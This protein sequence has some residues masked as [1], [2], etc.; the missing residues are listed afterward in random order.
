MLLSKEQKRAFDEIESS[1]NPVFITG[2]A[3]TGKSHLLKYLRQNSKFKANTIVAAFM[4]IA[5]LNVDGVTLHKFALKYQKSG[6]FFPTENEFQRFSRKKL[7]VIKNT[8]Q[9][10]IDEVSLV[11]AD[12]IDAIDRVFRFARKSDQP[13]GGVKMVMF[14][15]LFQLPPFVKN[16]VF[17]EITFSHIKRGLKFLD[18]YEIAEKPQFFYAHVF[19]LAPI[20]IIELR[21]VH[22]QAKGPFVE[23]LNRLRQGD[24]TRSDLETLNSKFSAKQTDSHVL[25]LMSLKENVEKH[26]REQL[27]ALDG[28]GPESF[29]AL[30]RY[31][32][33]DEI[34]DPEILAIPAPLVLEIKV[35]APVMFVRNDP[36]G[37]WANGTFGTVVGWTTNEINVA[38]DGRK[39]AVERSEWPIESPMVV[40]GENGRFM[41]GYETLGSIRQ[42]P[43]T[44]AWAITIHKSQGQTLSQVV[45]DFSQTFEAG[46]AYVAFSR[47]RS[48]EGLET[49]T[50][51]TKK[52]ILPH[53]E[54]I[55]RFMAHSPFQVLISWDQLPK[56]MHL[57]EKF[58]EDLSIFL[59]ETVNPEALIE[60]F[61]N[62]QPEFKNLW[63]DQE[64]FNH[65]GRMAYLMTE[66]GM[67]ALAYVLNMYL[68]F[69]NQAL[70]LTARALYGNKGTQVKPKQYPDSYLF[71]CRDW[72]LFKH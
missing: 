54:R 52:D 57:L 53:S 67:T 33:L 59:D 72:T 44:L 69:P 32:D 45:L 28:L 30:I 42:F 63:K 58:K 12:Y 38:I 4:G 39:V 15:D 10:I 62:D 46:M 49:L 55:F 40:K 2:S 22:R 7:E 31:E 27:L 11:R 16:F 51:F 24:V 1:V 34:S 64:K 8:E 48:L 23:A 17:P 37:R 6:L 61:A 21:E 41:I 3:G 68:R 50:H 26:N 71:A 13:F 60:L 20:D 65:Q 14:G 43:L 29:R 18:S 9:L 35:G 36:D 70:A 19:T 5:A 25:R 47:V 56:H 66:Y